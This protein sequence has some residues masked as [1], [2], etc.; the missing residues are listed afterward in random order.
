M[1]MD[2]RI[3]RGRPFFGKDVAGRM[4]A[5]TARE[6][7][8]GE[9]T[10]RCEA[11]ARPGCERLKDEDGSA[12]R[13]N[14][15]GRKHRQSISTARQEQHAGCGGR[16]NPGK[17]HDRP[18][19]LPGGIEDSRQGENQDPGEAGKPGQ[20]GSLTGE[21]G[22]AERLTDLIG[23][24][25]PKELPAEKTGVTNRRLCDLRERLLNVE[26]ILLSGRALSVS[27]RFGLQGLPAG[28]RPHGGKPCPGRR[29]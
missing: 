22:K 21:E 7:R 19:P 27:R 14:C 12:P 11:L 13:E 1:F 29:V 15:Q 26:T 17:E 20:Q 24:K 16:A 10:G 6:D 25:G 8:G 9:Q 2:E 18:R 5:E 4:A 28:A 23:L 3:S